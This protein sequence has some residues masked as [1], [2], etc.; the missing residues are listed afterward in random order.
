MPDIER[1]PNA[2][3]EGDAGFSDA[4][5]GVESTPEVQS[6]QGATGEEGGQ[7]VQNFEGLPF[8]STQEFVKGHKS[9]QEEYRKSRDEIYQLQN[10]LRQVAP[11]LAQLQQGSR[12]EDPFDIPK[13]LESFI[14]GPDKA[15]DSRADRRIEARL[16]DFTD[17][18]FAPLQ[19]ELNKLRTEKEIDRFMGDH[20]EINSD[21][22]NAL[23]DVFRATPWLR[24]MQGSISEKLDAALMVL[25]RKEPTRFS[26][27]QDAD[28]AAASR[29]LTSMKQSASSIGAKGGAKAKPGPKD[30]FDEV[31]EADAS[32]R[33]LWR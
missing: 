16:K 3:T 27:R 22:E 5:L 31:L 24:N 11:M 1:S 12:K 19:M 7:E 18:Q 10:Y 13:F 8:K 28:R 9:L 17:R 21:D 6:P 32:R 26:G 4:A 2:N 15:I 30:E 14:Q 33:A 29:N 20:P 23:L 25:S